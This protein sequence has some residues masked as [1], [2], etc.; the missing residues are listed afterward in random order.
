MRHKRTKREQDL[1]RELQAHLDLEAEER[2][3]DRSAAQRALGNTTLIKERTRE[4]WGFAWFDRLAQDLRY[5]CRMLKN[6]PGFAAVAILTAALGIGANTSIFSVVNAVL[7]RPLPYRDASRLVSPGNVGKDNLIGVGVAAYQYAAWRD[8]PGIFDGIAAYTG[9]RF[10]LTG[11]GEPEQLKAQAVTPGFLRVLGVAPAIG[12]DFTAGDAAPRGGRVALLS[13]SLWMRRFGSDPAILSRPMTLDGKLYSIA[14]VLPR[15]FEFPENSDVSLLVA[16]S[17]PAAQPSGAVFFYST[18]AR[19]KPGVTTARAQADLG[20]IN[21]R[22]EAAYPR[23]LGSLRLHTQVIGLHERLVGNVRPALLVLAG[24][25]A[26]VL[27]IVC[28]NICNLLLARAIARQ[29]EIAVRIALGAGRGRVL[30][31]LLTEGFLLA[32][33]GGAAGLAMAFGGVNLLRAIAPAN[34]PHIE[35]A[36]ISGVVLTF[37]IAIAVFSGILFGLAP[38]RG[39]SGIDPESALK[40]AARSTTGGRKHRR[41]ENLLIVSETAFALILLAGA[42]LLMRTFAGLTAIAPGFHPENVVT[43]QISLPYWKY[44]TSERLRAF[45]DTALES[46]QSGPGVEAAGEVACRPYGGFVMTSAAQVEGRPAPPNTEAEQVAVNYAAGDYFKSM[47]IP[48][49]EGRAIDRGD[50]A[51]RPDVVVVNQVFAR[52][53]F[54]GASPVGR[55]IKIAGITDWLQIAGVAGNVKQGGLAS[56][57]RPEVF[58]PA[59]QAEN[60]GSAQTLVIRST[61]DARILIPW[62]RARIAELDKDLPPP[63]IETMQTTMSSLVASQLFV[64]RLLALFAGIAITLAAIGIYS[65]LVYAVEQRTHEIGIR[66]ALGAKRGHIM[67]LIVGRGLRLSVAGAAIGLAGGLALT[68][69]LKSLLYGVTPHDPATLAGG[70][71]LIVAVALGAAYLPARRAVQQDPATTLRAE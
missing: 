50:Q 11:N 17:E 67:G 40:Q 35:N 52:R 18:I 45:L 37:N 5:G 30:R 15:N 13:H 66:L 34:V 42:G 55:R 23:R 39:V 54:P 21:Q 68:R 53:F 38:L 10:T 28:V 24:A 29:K 4:S 43:A 65:V 58:Q 3:G 7:L 33:T 61:A 16:I 59:A 47:G 64:M 20:L 44:P 51:G 32:A 31:Q 6:S 25:V 12:H 49:L 36:H 26:L 69:Y 60:G 14:G 63:E 41:M 1:E 19:M 22:V 46:V 70:C 56:E 48:I 57:P 71:A 27:L 9:R 62:L 8:Q 2:Q